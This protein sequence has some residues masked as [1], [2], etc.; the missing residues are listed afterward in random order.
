ML[1][2]LIACAAGADTSNE[3]TSTSTAASAPGGLAVMVWEYTCGEDAP[4]WVMPT[5]KI[6]GIQHVRAGNVTS[7]V[8]TGET[9]TVSPDEATPLINGRSPLDVCT[10][11]WIGG[12]VVVTYLP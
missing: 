1:I 9:V 11:E 2:T 6:V 7:G 12:R 5:G 8:L 3:E 10:A 4:E